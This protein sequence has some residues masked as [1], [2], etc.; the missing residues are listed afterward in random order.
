MPKSDF[1]F[2]TPDTACAS[3]CVFNKH[4]QH[5]QASGM[6]L[7]KSDLEDDT[8]YKNMDY[9][10][11]DKTKSM[12][13]GTD[14]INMSFIDKFQA[15]RY[16][17]EVLV[18]N[19]K[20]EIGKERSFVDYAPLVFRRIRNEI[21]EMSDDEYIRSIIPRTEKAQRGVLDA[22]YGEGQSGAFFY[23][24]HDSRFLV[25]TISSHEVQLMLDILPEYEKYLRDNKDT[26][27]TRCLGIHS[28][29]MYASVKYFV[30]MENVFIAK[31]KPHEVYDL[32]GS[33]QGRYTHHGPRTGKTMKDLDLKRF[34]ILSKRNLKFITKQLAKD[35]QF[36][37]DHQIMDYSLLLGIYHMTM[38]T[39]N[40]MTYSQGLDEMKERLEEY[41]GGVRAQITE[42]PGIYYMGVID[43]LQKYNW[44][45][46]LE[47]FFK[48]Y[49]QRKDRNAISCMDPQQY[50]S[51]FLIYMKAI[52]IDDNA[53]YRELKLSPRELKQQTVFVYPPHK[54]VDN[55]MRQMTRH[56]MRSIIVV[57]DENE[58]VND[59]SIPSFEVE[60]P[61][62]TAKMI[63]SMPITLKKFKKR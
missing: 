24:T 43:T 27:I 23:F 18:D 53:Y 61:D 36:L 5:L 11:N 2:E 4:P 3:C 54:I 44:K 19:S 20:G 31:L 50:R 46:K 21:L 8:H 51:R 56:G 52:M 28:C 63:L 22:K 17:T 15:G 34:I 58:V 41:A 62:T 38:A 16:T 33:W 10:R 37:A 9:M 39:D 1:S 47:R 48:V 57:E 42:G 55:N 26:L 35:T 14:T 13:K 59:N 40:P 32:K 45:K 29:T 12:T 49:V 6:I 30:V 7:E 25:K 60:V